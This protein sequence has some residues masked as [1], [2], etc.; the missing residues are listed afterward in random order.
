MRDAFAVLFFIAVGMLFDPKSLIQV[1]HIIAAVLFVV[2]IVKPAAAAITVR[3][4]G[5]PAATAIPI[6]AAFSQVG[7]FSFILGTVALGLGLLDESGWNALVATSIISIGFNPYIYD[8]ARRFSTAKKTKTTPVV[9]IPRQPLN[10]DLCILV[11][12]GPV[13][14]IVHRLLL[15]RGAEI[16]VIDLNLDTI[17]QLRAEGHNALYGDVLRSGTLED[18]G[19][20]VATSLILSTDIDDAAE[21][22]KHARQV[23]PDLK[24]LVRCAHLREAGSLRKA[25]A[26]V[27]VAG[28]AEVGVALAEVVTA[29]DEMACNLAA[30]HRETIRRMLY[31]TPMHLEEKSRSKS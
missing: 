19:I 23:N 6:G 29:G 12:Y 4:L 9:E 24:I 20:A 5:Q 1:P 11:G 31:D 7:E 18:A 8:W 22:V 14:K 26:T 13:G 28:E 30:D 16:T 27:V 3:M 10:P 25:G 21:V 2:I 15:D 17:R